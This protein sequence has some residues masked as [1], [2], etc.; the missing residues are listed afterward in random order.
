[1]PVYL[2]SSMRFD[3]CLPDCSSSHYIEIRIIAFRHNGSNPNYC[4]WHLSCRSSGMSTNQLQTLW[5]CRNKKLK[6]SC[7]REIV[8]RSVLLG[9]VALGA[10]RPM[11]KLS[12]G[13]S[14]NLCVGVS[15]CRCFGLSSVLWN[16]GGSDPDA[17]WHHKSDGSRDEAGSGVWGSV[18]GKGTFCG[19]YG[20][21]HCNQWGLDGV[22]VWLCLNRR[23]CGLG[24][25]MRWAEALL[26]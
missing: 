19:K 21:C 18:H 14:V 15:V 25:C 2:Y 6:L 8:R 13:R 23:S 4:N 3:R 22:G 11:I 16:N 26:Y 5:H 10:Q 12:R 7:C 1:M 9:R 17:I 20:A 24:W